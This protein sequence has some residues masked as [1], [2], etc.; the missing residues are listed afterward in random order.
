MKAALTQSLLEKTLK[1]RFVSDSAKKEGKGDALK[2]D[3][4]NK[5]AEAPEKSKVGMINNLMS[6]DLD[7]LSQARYAF[8]YPIV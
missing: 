8:I 5:K 4:A 6:T 3:E 1:I 7:Q 2:K